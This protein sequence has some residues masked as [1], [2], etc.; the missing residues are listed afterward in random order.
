VRLV[1]SCDV[2]RSLAAQAQGC[3]VGSTDLDSRCR[4]CRRQQTQSS[5]TSTGGLER[6]R[7]GRPGKQSVECRPESRGRRKQHLYRLHRHTGCRPP[8]LRAQ[9]T[10]LQ[11]RTGSAV[12]SKLAS[13]CKIFLAGQTF[14]S[15]LRAE[16]I[17]TVCIQ[18]QNSFP[19]V[20]G[21]CKFC[22]SASPRSCRCRW[23]LN[24]ARHD[25]ML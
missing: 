22:I 8:N 13:P 7:P 3:L 2:K 14:D 1:S 9:Q 15:G 21:I 17:S 18:T 5:R 25:D 20:C 19:L 24:M 6:Q 12:F 16:E 10:L 23:A 11:S 4:P